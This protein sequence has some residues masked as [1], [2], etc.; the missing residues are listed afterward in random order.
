MT[1]DQKKAAMKLLARASRRAAKAIGLTG[2]VAYLTV[3]VDEELDAILQSNMSPELARAI[4][5]SAIQIVDANSADIAQ[6]V[7]WATAKAPACPAPWT[8]REERK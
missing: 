8:P 1:P 5:E 4:L 6:S 3:V 2:T 7:D